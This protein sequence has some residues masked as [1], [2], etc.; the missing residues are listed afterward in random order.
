MNAK[1]HFQTLP[2]DLLAYIVSFLNPIQESCCNRGCSG[3]RRGLMS[4]AETSMALS[5]LALDRLWEQI[6]NLIPLLCSMP[7][8]L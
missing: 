6:P 4:L 5:G 7:S 1:S 8:D 2:P 3:D